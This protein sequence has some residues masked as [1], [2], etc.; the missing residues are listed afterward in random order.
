M[1]WVIGETLKIPFGGIEQL[2]TYLG[3]I[4]TTSAIRRYIR[5]EVMEI[6][7]R[8]SV[9]MFITAIPLGQHRICAGRRQGDMGFNMF[10][11]GHTRS[12]E[13]G[14]ATVTRCSAVV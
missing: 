3:R 12:F 7:W 4:H 11:V 9:F 14:S 1:R 13:E 6:Y 5:R 8:I 2:V 10:A